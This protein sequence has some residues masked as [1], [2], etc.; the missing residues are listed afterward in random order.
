MLSIIPP[1]IF[2]CHP[3]AKPPVLS[4]VKN[5][6]QAISYANII[7]LAY[8]FFF[9]F[10]DLG[11]VASWAASV[12]VHNTG[13]SAVRV[14]CV[15]HFISCSRDGWCF[16]LR[17]NYTEVVCPGIKIILCLYRNHFLCYR[18]S[19]ACEARCAICCDSEQQ[20]LSLVKNQKYS[21]GTMCCY[22]TVH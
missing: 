14:K 22:G 6:K 5:H 7:I 8:N 10:L 3:Q 9:T 11:H 19:D 2:Y 12:F 13:C 1:K 16:Y 18:S 4:S 20:Q 15:K 21:V 17:N